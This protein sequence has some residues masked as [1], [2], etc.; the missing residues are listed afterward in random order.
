MDDSEALYAWL[1]PAQPVLVPMGKCEAC[2][3]EVR[4][5]ELKTYNGKC[6]DCS[7]PQRAGTPFAHPKQYNDGRVIHKK[8]E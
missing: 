1:Y 7:V 5:C 6:E 8:L 2:G 3:N 4:V